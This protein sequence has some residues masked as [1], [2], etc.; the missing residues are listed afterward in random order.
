[1]S[2]N[3]A[4][5]AGEG[6]AG[7]QEQLTQDSAKRLG[8]LYVNRGMLE[9]R[10]AASLG[11]VDNLIGNDKLAGLEFVPQRPRRPRGNDMGDA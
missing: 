10:T 5:A 9:K 2:S 1:M 11:P 3:R 7:F 6:L 8:H 4:L